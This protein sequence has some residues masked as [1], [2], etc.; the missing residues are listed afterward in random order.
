MTPFRIII[1]FLVVSLMGLALIP[2]LSVNLNPT[3]QTPEISLHFNVRNADPTQVEKLATAPLE[4]ILSQLRDLD[5]LNSQSR[6]G[7]GNITLRFSKN[8]DL[9]YKRFEVATLVRQLY[10]E[11]DENVSYPILQSSGGDDEEGENKTILRYTVRGPFA[12]YRIKEITQESIVKPL[13]NVAGIESLP[14]YGANSLQISINFHSEKLEAYGLSPV[15]L[16]AALQQG[17]QLRYPG[18]A[19][20]ASNE[21]TFWYLIR[22][23]RIFN[24]SLN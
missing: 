9:A 19:Q 6:Y 22:G 8:A 14:V 7:S 5:E 18:L 24:K 3:Y 21:N 16:R 23:L 10:P 11:L 15:D 17:G 12:S 1:A 4:N 2:K 13:Q 20:S